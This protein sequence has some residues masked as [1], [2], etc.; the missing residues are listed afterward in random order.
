MAESLSCCLLKISGKARG[1]RERGTQ[2]N[3]EREPCLIFLTAG[4]PATSKVH[5]PH[6]S[7]S[8]GIPIDHGPLFKQFIEP[9]SLRF[10]DP[11]TPP[12]PLSKLCWLCTGRFDIVYC[13]WQSPSL[14]LFLT[15]SLFPFPQYCKEHRAPTGT[16]SLSKR[17]DREALQGVRGGSGQG[18]GGLKEERMKTRDVFLLFV[19]TTLI[20]GIYMHYYQIHYW[21]L[22][23]S[24]YSSKITNNRRGLGTFVH[25]VFHKQTVEL[26][27][28]NK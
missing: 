26:P 1:E 8:A 16:C 10:S 5:P 2:T 14:F 19:I 13:F 25:R 23:L 24:N 17:K 9:F 21:I 6:S 15:L 3:T 22:N 27:I 4:H 7:F 20:V 12:Y 18:R 28:Q 11:H